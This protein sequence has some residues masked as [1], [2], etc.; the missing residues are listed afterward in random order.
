MERRLFDFFNREFENEL[1]NQ[2]TMQAAYH[3]A[4]KKIE[5]DLDFTPYSSFD[6]FSR[7][8]RKKKKR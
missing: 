6:S 7:L 1:P 3:A 2:P 4:T 5:H 8:R